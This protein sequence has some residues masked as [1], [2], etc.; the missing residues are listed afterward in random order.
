MPEFVASDSIID[1]KPADLFEIPPTSWWE[2]ELCRIGKSRGWHWGMLI[3]HYSYGWLATESLSS[4]PAITRYN[5]PLAYIY[6][7]KG[8]APV[9]SDFITN[10]VTQYSNYCY[11]LTDDFRAAIWLLLKLYTSKLLHFM[12]NLDHPDQ[13]VT[14]PLSHSVNCVEYVCRLASQMGVKLIADEE[15]ATPLTLEQSTSLEYIGVH[16]IGAKQCQT[17][18]PGYVPYVVQRLG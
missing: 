5:Y 10:L 3:G 2:K 17:M 9:E 11:N 16:L 15:W 4:G 7:M 12:S 1:I 14:N 8:L 13:G 18:A 6:R